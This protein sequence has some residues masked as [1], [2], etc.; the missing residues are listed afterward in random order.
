MKAAG[1]VILFH[2]LHYPDYLKGSYHK[3]TIFLKVYNNRY[4][5]LFTKGL[6]KLLKLFVKILM[7]KHFCCSFYETVF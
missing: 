5:Y 1:N 4:L 6:K 7:N 3:K 2:T